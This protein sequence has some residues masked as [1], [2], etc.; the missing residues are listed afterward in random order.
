MIV[1][2]V[3]EVDMSDD[4]EFRMKKLEKWVE[5]DSTWIWRGAPCLQ[6]SLR[7]LFPGHGPVIAGEQP[8][9]ASD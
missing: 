6:G 2:V 4:P 5:K 7:M 8:W 9:Q 3:R 1:V